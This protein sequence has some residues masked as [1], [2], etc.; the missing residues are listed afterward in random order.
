MQT[1]DVLIIGS[2]LAG[3]SL[4]LRTAAH[5][6]VC[7]V[8]KRTI[9]DTASDW[10][11]G[12]IA[13]VLNEG[14]SV[15]SHIHDTLVAGAGLCDDAVTRLV[16]EHGKASVEWLINQGV[17]FTREDDNSGYH[18]TREGGH[19]HRRV[20]HADDA[21]GHA[22]QITLSEKVRQHPNITL[23]ESHIAVDLIT[24]LKVKKVTEHVADNACLGA[25]VL[26]TTTGNVITIAAQ[27]TVLAT[28]GAG[29]VYLYTTNP[30]VSTG[31]GVAMAW[32]AGCR[33]ANMEFIQFH[34]TC[35]FHPH[36]KSFLISEV[37]R[38]E[39]GLLKL[40]D[41]TRF[42]LDHDE[43][44]ELA[45]RD[46]VA[47]AIDFEMKKRGI[48][49]VY[50]DISH[51]TKAFIEAHFPNINQ[52]C[53]EL[54][55][56]ISQTP[57]PVVPAAHYSCGGIMTD[58]RGLTDIHHLYA[59]GETACTG[60]HGANRLA[61]NS[62]LECLVFGETAANDIL[63]QPQT[64]S[65]TL[66]YWDESRVTDADEE[67]LITH[68]WD[69]LR[70]FMWNYVGIVR[71][72]KRLSRALHRIHML[73]DEVHEFYSNFKISN[74][75]IEL[76]NL[77][78]VAELIVT[79]AIARKESRGLHYSKDHPNL[80]DDAIPTVLEPSNDYSLLDSSHGEHGS[81]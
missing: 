8:S 76:R 44:A 50:L 6:K 17:G 27:N 16:A 29:K 23:L 80:D 26:D 70:R 71:T 32:R 40:P 60:L 54:G 30:D 51:H 52:R 62:L 3:L 34:P 63:A 4:A 69:E 45:P 43:R 19:S 65:P 38:G 47:R 48:D 15:D 56:D 75:L 53:L 14:D 67:V 79:S 22:V 81:K 1:F 72:D 24:T 59:V 13:A 66:P 49:C 11:Q 25:Y 74:D 39:G 28:G 10:A 58:S 57:I 21:T 37:L 77:L 33:I 73:R 2:G 64:D 46:V 68:T 55:I 5:K 61:S 18:L 78:Q 31:D 41:G 9:N 36:A 20:I 7:L 42:M 35:L 12:G